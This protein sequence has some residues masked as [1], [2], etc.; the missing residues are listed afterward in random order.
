MEMYHSVSHTTWE[1]KYH[2]VF[3]SKYR[4]KGLYGQL[5]KHLGPVLKTLA[6]QKE[7]QI[8]EGHLLPDHVHMLIDIPPKYSGAQVVGYIKGKS[9]LYIARTFLGHTLNY[10][11]QHFWARGYYLSTV[12]REEKTIRDYVKKQEEHDRKLDQWNL[13]DKTPQDPN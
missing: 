8:E 11:G 3:I 2:V 6:A 12:G 4:K 7:C 13:F 5:R 10:G 9:A 1:C